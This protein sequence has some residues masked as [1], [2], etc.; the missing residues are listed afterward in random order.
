MIVVPSRLSRCNLQRS[1]KECQLT[2]KKVEGARFGIFPAETKVTLCTE[3]ALHRDIP[4]DHVSGRG[5]IALE[6]N[7]NFAARWRKG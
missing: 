6:Q 2:F 5:D 3:L 4:R 1:S 7:P